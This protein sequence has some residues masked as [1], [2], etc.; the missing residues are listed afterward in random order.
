M[1]AYDTTSD[2]KGGSLILLPKYDI[3]FTIFSF[4]DITTNNAVFTFTIR[5]AIYHQYSQEE[6]SRMLN[7][8][9]VFLHIAA[10]FENAHCLL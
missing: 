5:T 9:E 2:L 10:L 7:I 8:R 4:I 1:L 6:Q 3:M